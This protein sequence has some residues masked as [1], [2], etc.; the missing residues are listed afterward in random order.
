M[1][2]DGNLDVSLLRPIS[3]DLVHHAYHVLGER[4]GQVFSDGAALKYGGRYDLQNISRHRNFCL[5]E[6]LYNNFHPVDVHRV[7]KL[8][9]IFL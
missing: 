3:Y 7:K 2:V 4:A 8:T 6:I 1:G 5:E 9:G